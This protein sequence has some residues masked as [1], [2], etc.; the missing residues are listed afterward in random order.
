MKEHPVLFSSEMVQAILAGRK[1]QARWVMKPQPTASWDPRGRRYDTTVWRWQPEKGVDLNMEHLN[2][3][4]LG[5]YCPYGQPGD[6]LW[7]KEKA[8][9]WACRNVTAVRV[10]RVQEISETDARAEGVH[11]PNRFGAWRCYDQRVHSYRIGPIESYQTLWDSINAK[12]GHGWETNPW[13]WVVEFT[14]P[15]RRKP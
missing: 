10:E 6:R 8:K 15:D 5:Q 4:L 2:A 11:G 12:R 7:V 13:V 9:L 1:T 3:S 14:G